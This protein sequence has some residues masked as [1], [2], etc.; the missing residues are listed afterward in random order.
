[1]VDIM[2]I[3]WVNNVKHQFRW[4]I[5]LHTKKNY[6]GRHFAGRTEDGATEVPP[7]HRLLAHGHLLQR[8]ARL[9]HNGAKL[10]RKIRIG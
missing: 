1:M 2:L 3:Q 10:D 4:I 9:S 7:I 8:F 5:H 6:A